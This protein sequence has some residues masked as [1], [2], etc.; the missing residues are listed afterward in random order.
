METELGL[1]K[2]AVMADI[3]CGT[4][5]L[6][7]L[8]LREGYPIIGIEPNH[9]RRHLAEEALKT[10]GKFESLDGTAET[11]GLPRN[12][13]EFILSAQAFHLFDL[14]KTRL[15]WLRI[16]RP[17]GYV[18]LIWNERL[19]QTAFM[20]AYETFIL[21]TV[22]SFNQLMERRLNAESLN[23]FFAPAPV[24]HYQLNHSQL[25]DLN[26]LL[27][28][29]S[30]QCPAHLPVSPEFPSLRQQLH[31]IFRRHT[32]EGYVRLEYKTHVYAGR[33]QSQLT[34]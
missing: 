27:G 10:Y 11:T 2:G 9:A 6:S 8:F 28:H 22:G 34:P 1:G 13:C 25:I 24:S 14:Y 4:G 12:S 19:V 32:T 7:E 31:G 30:A 18:V 16:L 29:F 20:K 3:G 23:L 21:E 5:K 17:Q 15:E 26:G 33:L